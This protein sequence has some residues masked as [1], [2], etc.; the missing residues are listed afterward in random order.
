MAV[1]QSRRP[2]AATLVRRWLAVIA[3][4]LIGYA[5]YHPLRS[6]IETRDELSS[7][8]AEVAQLAAEKRALQERFEASTSAD[9]LAREARRLGFVRP[10]EHLF[11]VKGIA[12]WKKLHGITIDG[13]G[14]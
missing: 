11:I 10:G 13:G 4:V 1:R 14:K 6:W 2:P 3:I 9:A 12:A 8:R 7:R 5:Y